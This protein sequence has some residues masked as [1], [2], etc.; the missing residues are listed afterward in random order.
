MHIGEVAPPA[1]GHK[2]LFAYLVRTFQHHDAAAP[3]TRRDGTHK[4][5]SATADDNDIIVIHCCNIA[6]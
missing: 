5:G 6:D 4:T 3:L 1:S 2:N